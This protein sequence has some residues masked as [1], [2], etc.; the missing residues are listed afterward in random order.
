METD[1]ENAPFVL[2]EGD[3]ERWRRSIPPVDWDAFVS[4]HH[5][6]EPHARFVCALDMLVNIQKREQAIGT[7]I[8]AF[9]IAT[10]AHRDET[11]TARDAKE[12]YDLD[13]VRFLWDRL[14]RNRQRAVKTRI[15]NLVGSIIEERLVKHREAPDP[16]DPILK[17]ALSFVKM[18]RDEEKAEREAL[19]DRGIERLRGDVEA[20][21]K[22]FAAPSDPQLA[23]YLRTIVTKIGPNR[24]A[25]I[26][27]KALP[28][29]PKP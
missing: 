7:I 15:E 1:R 24:F 19:L 18:I 4:L 11:K 6:K 5:G 25:D 3:F 10:G 16:K 26:L 13:P 22:A 29:L 20:Q 17:D 9:C 8:E 2:S 23:D 28:S 27:E 12:S 21:R 14:E